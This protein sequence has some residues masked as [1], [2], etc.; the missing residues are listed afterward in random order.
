MNALTE[1]RLGP[2]IRRHKSEQDVAT[3]E[4]F[5]TACKV[6]FG[7]IY[8]DLAASESNAK[9]LNYF[10][11][12]QDSL[13]IPWSERTIGNL[14]FLNPPYS[15]IAPWAA[16]CDAEA[17]MGCRTLLLVPASV[18]SN[19]FRDHVHKKAFVLFLNGRITFVGQPTPYPRDLILCCYGFN[20]FT[21]YD[22]WTW[23][24]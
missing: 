12:E 20:G 7:E 3:P 4:N 23:K 19:W 17:R 6:R 15:N 16:K 10:T 14:C 22:T 1:P 5:I 8:F 21:G 2:T 18:G 13:Q 11:K 24:T 9:A